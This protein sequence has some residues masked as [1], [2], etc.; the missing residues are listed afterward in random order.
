MTNKA[1]FKGAL[2][3]GKSAEQERGF[4]LVELMVAIA[5]GLFLVAVV[6]VLFVSAKTTYLA[7]DANSRLQENARYATEL[8]GRQI[9]SAGYH[10]IVFA[11]LG[12]ANLFAP[13]FSTAF[14]GTALAATN[15]A[16]GAPDTI[17]L[18]FDSATDCLGQA[19]APTAINLF[20]INNQRQLECLGNGGANPAVVLD[21][22]ED[23]QVVFGQPVGNNFTFLAAGSAASTPIQTATSVRICLLL[24]TLADNDKRVTGGGAPTQ[25]YLD[26]SGTSRTATDG[27]LRRPVTL[28]LDLRNRLP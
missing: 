28:T 11:Q 20:R 21:D 16:S 18:S 22:V 3:G 10:Q 14:A 9:R 26:C 23:M 2:A 6:A 1:F 5:I 12:S 19:V 4:S 7:Q 15:G 25:T 8:F 13:S 27:Y 24:R 17:T